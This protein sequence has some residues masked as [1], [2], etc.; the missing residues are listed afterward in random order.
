[1]DGDAEETRWVVE[2]SFIMIRE[3]ASADRDVKGSSP[4]LGLGSR[5]EDLSRE[6]GY[7]R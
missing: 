4:C 2:R 6:V 1:M 5:D 7:T 3:T